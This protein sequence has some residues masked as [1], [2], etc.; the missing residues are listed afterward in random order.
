MG[1]HDTDEYGEIMNKLSDIEDRI[2][3]LEKGI[4]ELKGEIRMFGQSKPYYFYWVDGG[5]D[6][7]TGTN[8]LDAWRKGGYT[9]DDSPKLE[10]CMTEPNTHTW[11]ADRKKLVRNH[12][13]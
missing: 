8:Q 4:E 5:M 3:S 2:E 1:Y 12:I 6:T 11:D 10:I 13:H 9:A 7:I